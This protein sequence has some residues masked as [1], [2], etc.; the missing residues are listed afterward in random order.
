MLS[1]DHC[2]FRYDDAE[3]GKKTCI[4]KEHPVGKFRYIPNG[5]PGIETR[6]PLVFSAAYEG[7]AARGLEASRFVA[8]TSTNPAK[9]YGLHPRKGALIPGI[10]DADLV[11][12]YPEGG[13]PRFSLENSMLHHDVDYSPFEGRS[14]AN[15]PRYTILR[16]EVVWDRDNG[17]IVGRKGY[18]DFVRRGR[19]TMDGMWE[20]VEKR[21]EF[22]LEKL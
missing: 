22:D 15:W 16:G 10:S 20:T 12:W 2:P 13:L 7:D 19:S 4:T 3:Q 21:G 5:I 11:I 1:S 18:G 17:G 14:F 9:M 6:L 8:V